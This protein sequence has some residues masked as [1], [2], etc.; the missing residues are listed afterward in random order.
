MCHLETCNISHSPGGDD[1]GVALAVHNSG[2][3]RGAIYEDLE[4]GELTRKV[5]FGDGKDAF[6]S[7]EELRTAADWLASA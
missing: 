6:P 7:V 5:Y 3:D 4:T 1:E 2:H